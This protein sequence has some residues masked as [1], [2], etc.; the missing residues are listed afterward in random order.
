MSIG[1]K[2]EPTPT[3]GIDMR[4]RRLAAIAAI[5]ASGCVQPTPLTPCAA[6]TD[7]TSN[8]CAAAHATVRAQDAQ[9]AETEL[10][11]WVVFGGLGAYLGSKGL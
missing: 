6:G 10:L 3:K 7:S 9:R 2:L 4:Y 5:A 11:M 8:G 1:Y